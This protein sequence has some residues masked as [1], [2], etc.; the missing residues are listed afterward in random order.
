MS[1]VP[2][3]SLL[4]GLPIAYAEGYGKPHLGSAY[5]ADDAKAYELMEGAKCAACSCL[6]T[7]SHH[8]PPLSKGRHFLLS[9]RWGQ[10][11]LKPALIALCGSG[12]TG[13]HG[14]AHS[15]DMSV[16]WVWDSDDAA[17]RWWSGWLLSHGIA[18]HDP[19]L[20][21]YGHWEVGGRR[22]P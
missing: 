9:T 21:E 10:F 14:K 17:D 7:N 2:D 4:R 20:F 5:T 8:F 19:A 6:A 11:V 16:E 22:L 18:P 15:H 3:A 13:C 12:T 1:Y